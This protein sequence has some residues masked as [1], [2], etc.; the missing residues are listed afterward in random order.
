[1]SLVEVTDLRVDLDGSDV[2]VIDGISF[3]IDA[4]E[5]IGLVGESGSGKTTIGNALLGH[6]RR[7][8]RIVGGQVRI[9]EFDLRQLPEDKLRQIR[10]KVVAY[11]PQDPSAALN[12]A[13]RIGRQLSEMFEVHEPSAAADDRRE[14]IRSVLADVKLPQDDSFLGRYVHQL[15]GGQQQRIS[16]AMAFMLK[17]RLIV[18]DEP[19]TGL[20]VT[21]QAHVLTTVKGLCEKH[22]VA[23]LYVSHDLAVVGNIA[24]RVIVVYAGRIVETAERRSVFDHPLHPYTRQLLASIPVVSERRQLNPIPGQAPS[25]GA[26]LA[27][28]AFAP[29]CTHVLPECLAREVPIVDIADGHSVRCVR[30]HEMVSS[31]RPYEVLEPRCGGDRRTPILTVD[32]L[33]AYYG[34]VKVLHEVSLTLHTGECLALVGESGSGKT[35][36]SRAIIGLLSSWQ[37]SIMYKGEPLHQRARARS[38]VTRRELQYIFQSPYSS[39]NPRRAVGDIISVPLEQF[40][41]VKGR[42]ARRQVVAALDRVSLPERYASR[43]PDQLSGG[44][45]QRVAIARALIC[46]PEVLICDEITSALDVSVQASIV[47]LLETLQRDGNLTLLFVTHNLALVRTIADRVIVLNKGRIVETGPC[48]DVLDRPRDTYTQTLIGDTPA[49]AAAST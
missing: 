39:L 45:R 5:L 28:C 46:E 9:G 43:Y 38:A 41:S 44:E 3:S 26:R 2:D 34:D 13:L 14:R 49:L 30:V 37:G 11:V 7:G 12:P 6:S 48:A 8:A 36:L 31:S 4:G 22:Q 18:L 29:R 24:T 17:P 42:E 25:P 33:D 16:I 1:M 15:S 20:D 21:T 47:G 32:S 35:T 40:T 10:G 27:T 19:T 23:A